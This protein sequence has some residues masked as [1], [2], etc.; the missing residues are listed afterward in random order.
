[1]REEGY[2][3][4]LQL[5]HDDMMHWR[6][7]DNGICQFWISPADLAVRKGRREDDDRVSL[8]GGVPV[9]DE[10]MRG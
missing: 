7:G 4:L 1:M 5:T 2:I 8:M 9:G 6:F 10:P 3:M